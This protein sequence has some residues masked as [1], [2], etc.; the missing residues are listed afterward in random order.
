MT[1]WGVRIRPRARA[2]GGSP[3]GSKRS[4]GGSR[5]GAS[6]EPGRASPP[7]SLSAARSEARQG[8]VDLHPGLVEARERVA[9]IRSRHRC[10]PE[11]ALVVN[12][13]GR[14]EIGVVQDAVEGD[15]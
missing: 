10:Q 8:S 12:G 1:A 2:S 15:M 11:A 13:E 9:W 7:R 6:H 4:E 14:G 3:T 5:C